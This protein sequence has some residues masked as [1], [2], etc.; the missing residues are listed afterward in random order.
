LE[1]VLVAE[2]SYWVKNE[3]I[4]NLILVQEFVTLGENITVLGNVTPAAAISIAVYLSSSNVTKQMIC[5][6]KADGTF[7]ASFRP[8][9][10][11]IWEVQARFEGDTFL[12]ESASS[13]LSVEVKEPSIAMK[14]SV[15]IAGGIGAA[16]L[17]GVVIFWRKSKA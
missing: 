4:L 14:Y 16:V 3:A 17:V 7:T 6:T 1:N 13:S 12:Y 9:S 8:E 5:Y 11:G 2:N 15:Y 10:I